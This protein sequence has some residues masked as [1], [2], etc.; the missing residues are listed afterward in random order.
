[1]NIE[2]EHVELSTLGGTQVYVLTLN[3]T[4]D[5]GRTETMARVTPVDTFES[6][7]AEYGIDPST[8]AGWDDLMHLVIYERYLEQSGE[9]QLAD[10][11]HLFNAPT[12]ADARRAALKA[13]KTRRGKGRLTGKRGNSRHLAATIGEATALTNSGAV[14]PLEFIKATA[15]MDADHMRVKQEFTR[16]RRNALRAA[17]AGRNTVE[18]VDLDAATEQAARDTRGMPD[19]ESAE[20]L[21]DRLLGGPPTDDRRPPRPPRPAR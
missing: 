2:I 15:P 14:D 11:E 4:H 13:V 17:R 19:R 18:L 8:A 16:R 7:A 6:R 3:L 5:D 9:D 21:A 20:A 10:P 12:V 1:M